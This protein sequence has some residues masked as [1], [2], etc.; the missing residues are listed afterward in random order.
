MSKGKQEANSN[1]PSDA[2]VSRSKVLCMYLSISNVTHII[3]TMKFYVP[4][5]HMQRIERNNYKKKGQT[6]KEVCRID[7]AGDKSVARLTLEGMSAEKKHAVDEK[8]LKAKIYKEV[9]GTILNIA[10]RE[11][12]EL[13]NIEHLTK[14]VVEIGEMIHP[15]KPTIEKLLQT[16]HAIK[17]GDWVEVLCEYA[18]GT[19]SDGVVGSIRK[20]T[21]DS[22]DRAWCTVSYVLDKRIETGIDQKRITVTIM[23]YKDTTWRMSW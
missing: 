1:P 8:T 2:K 11:Q 17:V 7:L 4:T 14:S 5:V 18:P 22:D 12:L 3:H 19:C 16:D 21:R 20:I 23:P 10:H 13:L 6:E 15:L 9:K